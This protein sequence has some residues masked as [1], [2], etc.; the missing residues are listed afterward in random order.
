MLRVTSITNILILYGNA[1]CADSSQVL[2]KNLFML[3]ST[4]KL[5][6]I[7]PWKFKIFPLSIKKTQTH[8]LR[9]KE[10]RGVEFSSNE[11]WPQQNFNVFFFISM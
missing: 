6:K 9:E 8:E 5:V 2:V 11:Q 1:F 10:S 4:T 7:L 3:L